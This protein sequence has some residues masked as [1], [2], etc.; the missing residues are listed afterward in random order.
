MDVKETLKKYN[1]DPEIK[2]T[3]QPA[4]SA[5]SKHLFRLCHPFLFICPWCVATRY[6][7]VA[8]FI[9]FIFFIL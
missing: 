2:H 5:I 9:L 8:C 3:D 4:P 7:L 1:K 6:V